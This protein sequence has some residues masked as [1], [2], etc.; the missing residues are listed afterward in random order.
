MLIS[1]PAFGDQTA[2]DKKTVEYGIV[3]CVTGKE[4][5]VAQRLEKKITGLNAI[6]PVK[7]RYRRM[8]GVAHKEE[9]IL[10]PGYVFIRATRYVKS[11][12]ILQDRDVLK[13]LYTE[14]EGKEW[15]LSGRDRIIVETF[16][17]INGVIGLSSAYFDERGRIRVTD[18]FLKQHDGQ[19]LRVNKRAK[20][21]EICVEIGGRAFDLWLGFE[22]TD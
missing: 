19:I 5:G 9:A 18:G 1:M 3:F 12:D 22:E 21:A 8:G 7:L 2:E 10:F 16:F 13:L 6:S 17:R 14:S 20:T 4:L 11:M 15:H